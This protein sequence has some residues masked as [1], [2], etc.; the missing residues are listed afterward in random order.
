M[1]ARP[2]ID[3]AAEHQRGRAR[4]HRAP[5]DVGRRE[6]HGN[7]TRA[8][9]STLRNPAGH[10]RFPARAGTRNGFP[11]DRTRSEELMVDRYGGAWFYR[12]TI[13]AQSLG[14]SL[15]LAREIAAAVRAA[16]G[17][18]LIVGRVRDC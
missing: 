8:A 18:A 4:V 6:R 17:R 12:S 10:L 1:P 11:I 15:N 16:G 2:R 3:V 7:S 14:M 9:R 5:R 13:E